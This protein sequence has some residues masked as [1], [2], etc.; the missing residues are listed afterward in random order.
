MTIAIVE[1]A[2]EDAVS[3][4][5]VVTGV[6]LHTDLGS[7]YTSNEY[8]K[9]L[10]ELTITNSY[11]RKGCPYDNAGIEAFHALLKKEHVYQRPAYQTFEESRR[12]ILN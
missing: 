3:N 6:I 4:R 5:N 9:R 8:E 1:K 12:K 2:L 10:K 7:D 11:I